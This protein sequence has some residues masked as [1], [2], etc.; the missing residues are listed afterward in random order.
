MTC[1]S[2][3]MLPLHVLEM[4]LNLSH[5]SDDIIHLSGFG[6]EDTGV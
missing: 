3:A 4:E 1:I 2:E 5:L 6:G